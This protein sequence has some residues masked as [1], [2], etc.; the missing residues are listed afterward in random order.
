[1]QSCQLRSILRVC[2]PSG[3]AFLF[4]QTCPTIVQPRHAIL[5]NITEDTKH[6]TAHNSISSGQNEPSFTC[7]ASYGH[8]MAGTRQQTQ[9]LVKWPVAGCGGGGGAK[10]TCEGYGEQQLHG[11][12]LGLHCWPEAGSTGVTGGSGATGGRHTG[13][14]ASHCPP[15]HSITLFTASATLLLHLREGP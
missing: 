1:M 6:I 11:P 14:T 3:L 10:L 13:P 7:L 5:D 12:S 9:E 8:P 15:L 4:G 2:F